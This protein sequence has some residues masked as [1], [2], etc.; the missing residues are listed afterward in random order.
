MSKRCRDERGERG[1]RAERV[2]AVRENRRHAV[3]IERVIRQ[4]R[5]NLVHLDAVETHASAKIE[6]LVKFAHVPHLSNRRGRERHLAVGRKPRER[7]H[8]LKRSALG[9]A[10]RRGSRRRNRRLPLR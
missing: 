9:G 3:S 2:R 7:G 1:E 8:L 10:E 5:N 6:R 4:R